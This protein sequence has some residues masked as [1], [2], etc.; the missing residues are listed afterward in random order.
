MGAFPVILFIVIAVA[1]II[2]N[3][4][5]QQKRKKELWAFSEQHGLRFDPERNYDIEEQFPHFKCLHQGDGD[6]YAYN[7]MRG[8]WGGRAVLAFD[9]HYETRST[10]SKG[11][12]QTHSH[13]FSAVIL[14]SDVPLKPLFIRPEGFFD[15]IGEFFGWD[16]I[17]FESTEFSRAFYVT[18]EDKKW[19]YDVIHARMM[20]FLLGAPRMTIQF[21]QF[22]IIAHTGRVFG[23]EDFE[24]AARLLDGMLKRLPEYLVK[25]QMGEN[26]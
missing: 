14:S 11:N 15:K 7:Q 21:D 5:Q 6:R 3:Y 19:A 22:Q 12:R 1:V 26:G 10:D 18:A 13:R 2:L 16:D 24:N 25:E 20:E 4:Y 23:V 8:E 9:Y 17:D